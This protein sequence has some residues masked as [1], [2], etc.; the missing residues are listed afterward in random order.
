MLTCL[1]IKIAKGYFMRSAFESFRA[2]VSNISFFEVLQ[3]Q[4]TQGYMSAQI[5]FLNISG[6]QFFQ[7]LVFCR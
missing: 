2:I 6:P 4:H 7:H 1:K 3:F 5:K